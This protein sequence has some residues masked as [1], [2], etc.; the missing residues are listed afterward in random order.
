MKVASSRTRKAAKRQTGS[1]ALVLRLPSR[2]KISVGKLGVVSFPRGYYIY[3]GSA[4][5]GLRARTARHLRSDK[6]LH[7]HADYLSAEVPWSQV[8]EM[9]DGQRW[10]CEWAKEASGFTESTRG[11]T[12]PA[13]GFGSSDCKCPTHLIRVNNPQEVRALLRSLSPAPRRI[14]LGTITAA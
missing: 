14:R 5:G 8:W 12:H 1:Y 3:F 10:E 7:W 4:L 13:P 11:I 9:A 2:R 6:K